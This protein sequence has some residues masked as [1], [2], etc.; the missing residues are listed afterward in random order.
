MRRSKLIIGLVSL[1]VVIAVAATAYIYDEHLT[2]TP[3]D[4][5]ESA[6][7]Y[8]PSGPVG[9]PDREPRPVTIIGDSYSR[10]SAT[11]GPEGNWTRLMAR[12]MYADER[13]VLLSIAAEAEA[14][15][16]EATGA[17]QDFVSMVDGL[18]DSDTELVIAMGS[19]NDIPLDPSIR[20]R[21]FV[22]KVRE[23]SPNARVLLVGTFCGPLDDCASF[24]RYNDQLSAVALSVGAEFVDPIAE[25]WFQGTDRGLI[26]VDNV[27]PTNAG[28][29]YIADKLHDRVS[30]LLP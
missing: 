2:A 11:G 26:G 9:V 19:R 12:S 23:E 20:A 1:F 4:G 17:G 18:A 3:A 29:Q 27:H 25:N 7:V 22:E 15:Y 6:A 16:V 21:A 14:G 28:Y 13:P 10:G 24:Q 5:D 8:S 30:A